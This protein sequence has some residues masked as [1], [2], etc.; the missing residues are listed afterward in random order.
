MDEPI[1]T[2][3]V[4]PVK[5]EAEIAADTAVKAAT[6]AIVETAIVAEKVEDVEIVIEEN[7]ESIEWLSKNQQA[8]TSE[9]V[10]LSSNQTMIL[11]E[12]RELSK[13]L[14]ELK[15]PPPA[16]QSQVEPVIVV[17]SPENADAPLEVE[18]QSPPKKKRHK[19]L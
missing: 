18:P 4:E 5:T 12:V 19:F 16:P 8:M 6:V 13:L 3:V 10:T 17:S 14:Q 1:E 2:V 11:S 9:L 7:K 15:S